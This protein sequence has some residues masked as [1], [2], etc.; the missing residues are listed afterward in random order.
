[1]GLYKLINT[2]YNCI[3]NTGNTQNGGNKMDR[4]QIIDFVNEKVLPGAEI[5]N[6]DWF[7]NGKDIFRNIIK[8]IEKWRI[9][10]NTHIEM[11]AEIIDGALYING[12][13]VKRVASKLPRMAHDEEAAYW[14]GR[15]LARQGC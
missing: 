12:E 3:K 11:D 15:I 4:K 5:D 14:E 9:G 7:Y 1:M 10:K 8:A 13:S 2:S 6:G